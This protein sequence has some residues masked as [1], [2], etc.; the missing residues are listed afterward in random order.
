MI[1]PGT[2][3][4]TSFGSLLLFRFLIIWY[5]ILNLYKYSAASYLVIGLSKEIASDGEIT[6]ICRAFS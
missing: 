5:L 6:H 1:E 3:L 4:I 2:V